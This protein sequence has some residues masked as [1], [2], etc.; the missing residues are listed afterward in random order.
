MTVQGVKLLVTGKSDYWTVLASAFT[1][2]GPEAPPTD[3]I[4]MISYTRDCFQKGAAF[5]L[6]GRFHTA[7][8]YLKKYLAQFVKIADMGTANRGDWLA[9]YFSMA[10]LSDSWN[11]DTLCR[12]I[13]QSREEFNN[14]VRRCRAD[15]L[16]KA[17]RGIPGVRAKNREEEP[18]VIPADNK[19]NSLAYAEAADM[20]LEIARLQLLN[21]NLSFT[22]K[23]CSVAESLLKRNRKILREK[24]GDGALAAMERLEQLAPVI[25]DQVEMTDFISRM[26]L[27]AR[28]N[29]TETVTVN[30]IA[31]VRSSYSEQFYLGRNG[32]TVFER[33]TIQNQSSSR[34]N[35][36]WSENIVI[37]SGIAEE[38]V[39][40][41]FDRFFEKYVAP[42]DNFIDLPGISF[43]HQVE[44]ILLKCLVFK[45]QLSGQDEKS[46][47]RLF[48]ACVI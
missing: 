41:Q 38:K 3:P 27:R 37:D 10:V 43:I 36:Y 6:A 44:W 17:V 31:K 14:Y 42:V 21:L 34:L 46:K 29:N 48:R 9:R 39:H 12:A 4:A 7:G 32:E 20:I 11:R 47:T 16:Y 5:A 8:L 15:G 24:G 25:Q 2:R 35:P 33:N 1:D 22:K 28:S 30:R 19:D 18:P 13:D 40:Q 45:K 26:M 23:I